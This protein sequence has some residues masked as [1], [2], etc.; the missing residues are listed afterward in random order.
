MPT[1][2]IIT[3]TNS[4]RGSKRVIQCRL[5]QGGLTADIMIQD[6]CGPKVSPGLET[7][8]A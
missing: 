7:L 2:Q 8:K 3:I 1:D 6:A 5:E 4:P